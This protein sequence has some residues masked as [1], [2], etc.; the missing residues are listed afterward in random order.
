MKKKSVGTK[1]LSIFIG[2]VGSFIWFI[3]MLIVF[4]DAEPIDYLVSIPIVFLLLMAF[5]RGIYWV[6]QGFKID[7]GKE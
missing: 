4:E 5:V 1:R 2:V 6:V 3:F 7:K